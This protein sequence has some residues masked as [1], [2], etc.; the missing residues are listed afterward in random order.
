M[1]VGVNQDHVDI[2][3]HRLNKAT[4]L[5]LVKRLVIQTAVPGNRPYAERISTSASFSVTRP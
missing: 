5:L 1:R 4:Q 3:K 2:F